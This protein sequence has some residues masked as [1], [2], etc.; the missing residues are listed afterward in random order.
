MHIHILSVPKL[1][2][3]SVP[4]HFQKNNLAFSESE[5][6]R[7]FWILQMNAAN[8]LK[9]NGWLVVSTPRKSINHMEILGLIVPTM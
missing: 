3:P 9:K 1:E 4:R 5:K 2:K 7:V 6:A 8:K